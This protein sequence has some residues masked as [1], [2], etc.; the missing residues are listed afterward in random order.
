[1]RSTF[2]WRRVL[3]WFRRS[4]GLDEA[5]EQFLAGSSD[6]ADLE[7][8]LRALERGCIRVIPVTFNH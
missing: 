2:H 6:L 7:R 5:A 1:M 3:G 8:R 4:G